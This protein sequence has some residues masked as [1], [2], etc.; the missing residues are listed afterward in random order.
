MITKNV[1]GGNKF[2]HLL[3]KLMPDGQQRKLINKPQQSTQLKNGVLVDMTHYGIKL[4]C[5]YRNDMQQ[6]F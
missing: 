3:N 5:W 2:I 4:L 6:K 1:S